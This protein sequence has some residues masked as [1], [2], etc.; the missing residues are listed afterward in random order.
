M[1]IIQASVF[2]CEN[3]APNR[4]CKLSHKFMEHRTKKGKAC[5]AQISGPKYRSIFKVKMS[6]QENFI[7]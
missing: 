1:S 2:I 7:S 4:P 6:T 3:D 5:F